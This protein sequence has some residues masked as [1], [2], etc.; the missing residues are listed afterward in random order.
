MF[1][2]QFFQGV[3]TLM[4]P[5]NRTWESYNRKGGSSQFLPKLKLGVSLAQQQDEC[6]GITS[7]QEELLP[8]RPFLFWKRF[9]RGVKQSI[10]LAR[11]TDQGLT[12]PA[13]RTAAT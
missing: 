6:H 7:E 8:R 10:R 9:A 12:R 2:R 13:C 11:L 5:S 3:A 4:P 1:G